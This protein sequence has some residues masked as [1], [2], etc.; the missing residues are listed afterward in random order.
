MKYIIASALCVILLASCGQDPS[1]PTTTTP[2]YFPLQIGNWWEYA[3]D[4]VA[5]DGSKFIYAYTDRMEI[6]DDSVV[7]GKKYYVAN[8]K[9]GGSDMYNQT[10]FLIK[11]TDGNLSVTANI[12]PQNIYD[13]ILLVLYYFNKPKGEVWNRNPYSSG[14]FME[15]FRYNDT[16]TVPAGVFSP[17][18]VIKSSNAIG[19][20]SDF[21]IFAPGIGM[22]QR[23]PVSILFNPN[24]P[25]IERGGIRKSLT[26]AFINNVA[27]PR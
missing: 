9:R 11:D 17:N 15:I 18:C 21:S 2:D 6:I 4:T 1:T 19:Q 3:V 27:Y 10:Y 12:Y 20:Y 22:I 8:A 25:V 16:T 26:K 24:T 7:N 5:A 14:N 13:S 23:Y